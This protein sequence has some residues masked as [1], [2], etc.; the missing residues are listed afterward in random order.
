MGADIKR[1][2][3][4]GQ[5]IKDDSAKKP[6]DLAKLIKLALAERVLRRQR[7]LLALVRIA[8]V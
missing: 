3:Q 5:V 1:G 6:C 7:R 2:S 8:I 4:M